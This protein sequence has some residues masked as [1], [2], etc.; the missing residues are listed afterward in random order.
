MLTASFGVAARFWRLDSLFVDLS[1][2]AAMA[3]R[4]ES[5]VGRVRLSTLAVK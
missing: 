4:Q 5:F 3:L 1:A 2:G